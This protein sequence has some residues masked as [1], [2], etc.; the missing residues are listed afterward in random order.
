[1]EPEVQSS[2]TQPETDKKPSWFWLILIFLAVVAV[3]VVAFLW[4]SNQQLK[5]SRET[6]PSPSPMLE[7][8]ATEEESSSDE[9]SSIET[10]LQG[11]D[12]SDLDQE[13]EDIEAEIASP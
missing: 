9:V 11:T 5:S 1:M 4:F 10:D 8:E 13:L 7:Y 2:M 12:L 6:A 3:A